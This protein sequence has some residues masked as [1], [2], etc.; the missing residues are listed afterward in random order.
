MVVLICTISF[1]VCVL[2]NCKINE[3]E[4]DPW[5]LL[6]GR[7][8]FCCK[9]RIK[10]SNVT[11]F[12]YSLITRNL[13]DFPSPCSHWHTD[14]WIDE[15]KISACTVLRLL[16]TARKTAIL[17]TPSGRLKRQNHDFS[18]ILRTAMLPWWQVFV[19]KLQ[20]SSLDTKRWVSQFAF[21]NARIRFNGFSRSI[22]LWTLMK[23][24]TLDFWGN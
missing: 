4:F 1:A 23:N 20:Q 5:I 2:T 18:A 8:S 19:H 3:Y 16:T 15:S 11:A 22:A 7:Q 10:V 9:P 21:C 13:E 14:L 24:R 17:W 12:T 6:Q